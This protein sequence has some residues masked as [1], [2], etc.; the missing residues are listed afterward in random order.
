MGG[1]AADARVEVILI[2]SI[3]VA[4]AD[5]PDRCQACQSNNKYIDQAQFSTVA[6]V[7]DVV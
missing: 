1:D 3:A 4:R 2:D 6:S 5:T 7:M